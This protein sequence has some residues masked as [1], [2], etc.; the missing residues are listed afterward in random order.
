LKE[1][2]LETE[3]QVDGSEFSADAEL[4]TEAGKAARKCI[5]H[6]AR[7]I[8]STPRVLIKCYT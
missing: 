8:S 6:A 7:F 2:A 5:L 3:I 1:A 4:N